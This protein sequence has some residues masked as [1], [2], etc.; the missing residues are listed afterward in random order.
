MHFIILH[1][2]F[3]LSADLFPLLNEQSAATTCDNI[4]IFREVCPLFPPP[5]SQVSFSYLLRRRSVPFHRL[6]PLHTVTVVFRIMETRGAVYLLAW[7]R[8][9]HFAS[10]RL[11]QNP[12]SSH[13]RVFAVSWMM[14]PITG[15]CL[16]IWSLMQSHRVVVSSFRR[17]GSYGC[18]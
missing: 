16:F 2:C 12:V 15:P 8:R 4:S 3:H 1:R 7:K 14:S 10:D 5:R 6:H 13:H 17:D 11:V 9:C 18:H